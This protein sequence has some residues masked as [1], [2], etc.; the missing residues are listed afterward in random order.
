MEKTYKL[1]GIEYQPGEMQKS[2][3]ERVNAERNKMASSEKTEDVGASGQEMSAS[4]DMGASGGASG[5]DPTLVVV[6][7]P[8]KLTPEEMAMD[9][10]LIV[11]PDEE[12]AA[13][14][15]MS[16]SGVSGG[17]ASLT[18]EVGPE[19]EAASGGASGDPVNMMAVTMFGAPKVIVW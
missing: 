19:D 15:D 7:E 16:A 1:G 8:D 14:G 13:S 2:F 17:D 12:I 5:M 10:R 4:G 9:P 18:V 11:D 6:P 3:G